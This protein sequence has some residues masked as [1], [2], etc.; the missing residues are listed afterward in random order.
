VLRYADDSVVGFEKEG[1]AEALGGEAAGG[2][3]GEGGVVGVGVVVVGD[4]LVGV[5]G[6]GAGVVALDGGDAVLGIVGV[7]GLLALGVGFRGHLA[8]R[9]VDERDGA[10]FRVGGGDKL[11][12]GVEGEGAGLRRGAAGHGDLGELIEGGVGRVLWPVS[13]LMGWPK[14]SK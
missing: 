3:L 14:P 5:G 4:G 12:V 8:V 1:D 13:V 9:V 11:A 6:G 2:G 10:G 7:F